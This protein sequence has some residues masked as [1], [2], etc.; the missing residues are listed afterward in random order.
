ME[1]KQV[2]GDRRTIRF[3]DPNKPVSKDKIQV[4]LEAA[5]RSSR[6]VNGDFAKAVVCYRDELPEEILEQ[7]KQPTTTVQ[8]E[9]APVFI[10]WWGDLEYHVGGQER[11]KELVDLGALPVTH[12]WSHAYVDEVA[13]GQVV[14]TIAADPATNAW[15]TSVECGIA[16]NQ[17]MLA[18]VDEGLGVGL[19]AFNVDIARA[20]FDIPDTWIPMWVMLVGYPSEDRL[21]GGQRPRR[22]LGDH[23]FLGRYGTPW[24][25]D[26]AVTE[27][28][29][30][31]GMIQKPMT[32]HEAERHAEIRE[33]AE[34]FGLPL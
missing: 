26:P 21:G 33:L 4:M 18:A 31:Q 8:M 23:F 32:G 13:Y 14:K 30:A 25:E 27:R 20:A 5:N 6:S 9:L 12:G 29:T 1:F 16:I 17:A 3:F 11:L 34:R 15:M 24:Q 22:P 7:I 10:F 28:L 19:S 2:V